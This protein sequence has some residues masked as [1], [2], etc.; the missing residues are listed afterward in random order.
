MSD[1][2]APRHALRVSTLTEAGHPAWDRFVLGHEHG[3]P[4]HMTAW[5]KSIQETYGFRPWYLEA[6]E[7]G[8]TRGVLPLFLVKSPLMGKALISVPF[9]VYGGALSDSPEAAARLRAEV[10]RL[11]R[12]LGVQHVELRN[13]YPEQA[14][15]FAPVERYVTFTQGIGADEEALLQSIPRKVRYMVRKALKEEF[16]TRRQSTDYGA[17]IDLYTRNL[18]RLGTPSFPKKHF[19][20]LRRHFGGAVDV[21]EV[22]YRGEV[23]AA[24]LTF[25]FRDQVMPYYG[26]SDPKFHAL[27]PNNFMYFDLMRWGGANGF[28]TFDFGRSKISSGGSYDFKGHWGMQERV[29]PYEML[30]VKRKELPDF[31][32]RNPL[33]EL[34]IKIWQRLPL[35]VTRAVGPYFLRMVP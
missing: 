3:S 23:A 20:A 2:S 16:T 35:A 30:L 33:F 8:R 14:L 25:Y 10:V 13:A 32:P 6:S 9:G 21:R 26:A 11:G 7:G 31:S 12:E 17:F 15:G 28:R 19:D 1:S 18:R 24:V 27:A 4:F 5:M 29:L 22:V 34:P